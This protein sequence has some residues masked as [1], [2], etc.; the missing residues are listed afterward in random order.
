MKY[1]I[2]FCMFSFTWTC[3]YSNTSIKFYEEPIYEFY[4]ASMKSNNIALKLKYDAVTQIS[5][6]YNLRTNTLYLSTSL[7]HSLTNNPCSYLH[8]HIC[9]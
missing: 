1:E 3:F 2:V 5:V 7:L 8:T 4:E 9:K 6:I